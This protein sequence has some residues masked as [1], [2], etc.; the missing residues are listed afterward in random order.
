[1][2]LCKL[3]IMYLVIDVWCC[4]PVRVIVPYRTTCTQNKVFA[5]GTSAG[6]EE[7]PFFLATAISLVSLAVRKEATGKRKRE[8]GAR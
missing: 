4:L 3:E 6:F 2:K 5:A 8:E 1:M 7:A